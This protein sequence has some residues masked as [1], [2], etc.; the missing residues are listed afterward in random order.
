MPRKRPAGGV[1]HTGHERRH[2]QAHALVPARVQVH[3]ARKR[4]YARTGAGIGHVRAR[5]LRCSELG[6]RP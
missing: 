4:L 2:T 5:A 3:A 1:L 6:L